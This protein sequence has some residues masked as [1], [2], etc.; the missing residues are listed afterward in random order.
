MKQIKTLKKIKKYINYWGIFGIIFLVLTMLSWL[1]RLD[2]GVGLISS[3]LTI[4]YYQ[5]QIYWKTKYYKTLMFNK[6]MEQRDK[7]G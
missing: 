1:F 7:N 5:E 6:L 2:I 3:L 4:L